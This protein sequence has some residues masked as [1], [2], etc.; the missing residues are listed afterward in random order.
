[1]SWIPEEDIET[2]ALA[3]M[4]SGGGS[5]RATTLV[6]DEYCDAH[7]IYPTETHRNPRQDVFVLVTKQLHKLHE[8]YWEAQ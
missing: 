5:H 2:L 3:A 7:G 4:L 8:P 6:V 1:M